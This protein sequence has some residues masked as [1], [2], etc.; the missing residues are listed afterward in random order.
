MGRFLVCWQA[1][2]SR[3][4]GRQV[5]VA[6]PPLQG[7]CDLRR[8]RVPPSV[9]L[10][11]AG[12]RSGVPAEGLESRPCSE[13]HAPLGPRSFSRC[14]PTDKRF[15][16]CQ[17]GPCQDPWRTRGPGT[18]PW[19]SLSSPT[20]ASRMHRSHTSENQAPRDWLSMPAQPD[21]ISGHAGH[22]DTT[23]S[24]LGA[25]RQGQ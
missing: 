16:R 7:P 19:H 10:S 13:G 21:H 1:S 14:Q 24:G 11:V 12:L 2:S 9:R 20:A 15:W 3:E 17:R 8:P 23:P 22:P 6:S 5:S 25:P 18:Q 4:G